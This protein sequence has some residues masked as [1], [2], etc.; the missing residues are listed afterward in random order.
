VSQPDEILQIETPENVAF[1]Y[2]VAGIGSRF[3]A[4]LVDT[5][6]IALIQVVVYTVLI[7]VVSVVLNGADEDIA[8]R[9]LLALGVLVSFVMLWGYYLFFELM[10][11]GQSPGK[12]LVKLRVIRSDGMPVTLSE[13]LIRNLVRL[14]DFL[15]VSYGIG[16][17]TMFV[18]KQSQRLG[19]LAAGT[20][21]VFDQTDISLESLKERPIMSRA[22]PLSVAG[23]LPPLPTDVRVDRLTAQDIR[24]MEEYLRRRYELANSRRMGL[25]LVERIQQRLELPPNPQPLERPDHW[26]MQVLD[27]YRGQNKPQ[28]TGP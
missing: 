14:V 28:Q 24:L 27:A 19:D 15:P 17:I 16:V 11:N 7:L 1:G 26:L 8:G 12:R 10:W 2:E 13:V 4:A 25:R 21:V 9:W 22:T 20:L 18:S 6:I 5:L 3:L 23:T